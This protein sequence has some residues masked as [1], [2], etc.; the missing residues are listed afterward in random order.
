MATKTDKGEK[1][2]VETPK[3]DKVTKFFIQRIQAWMD[4]ECKNDAE[5]AELVK[6][7]P[8]KTVEGCCNYILKVAK[9][10]RQ[11]GWDDAEV[12]GMVRHFWDED[13]LKDPGAQNPSKII[14]SGHID[15][16][17]EEKAE[18]MEQA[19]AEYKLELKKAA[20][21]AE[22]ERKEKERAAAEERRRKLEEKREKELAMQGDLFGF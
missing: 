17:A 2:K 18:A 1:A 5:F 3:T 22:A 20:A 21:K 8:G 16:T 15:L 10:T 19:K 11:V 7:K 9:D 12:F 13:D 4:E 6:S 14:V